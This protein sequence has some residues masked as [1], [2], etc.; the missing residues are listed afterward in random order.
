MH[1]AARQRY[2]NRGSKA[3]WEATKAADWSFASGLGTAALFS[4]SVPILV[5]LPFLALAAAVA[6]GP[7]VWATYAAIALVITALV[8][9]W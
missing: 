7:I 6:Y 3:E 2:Y 9:G 1:A 5:V 4:L 8:K